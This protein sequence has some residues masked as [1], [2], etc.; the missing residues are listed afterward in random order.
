[1]H[2][3]GLMLA[4]KWRQ[5]CRSQ[6]DRKSCN[7][8][9]KNIEGTIVHGIRSKKDKESQASDW[10]LKPSQI[11]PDQDGTVM[12]KGTDVFRMIGHS[13]PTI[14]GGQMVKAGVPIEGD[15][16]AEFLDS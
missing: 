16:Q 12:R 1:M 15:I 14:S 13:A 11:A 10:D 3:R 7:S 5:F 4:A 6:S 8:R 9:S 2:R